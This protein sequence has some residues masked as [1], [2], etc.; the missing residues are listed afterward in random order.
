MIKLKLLTSFVLC[1]LLSFSQ[2]KKGSKLKYAD[3]KELINAMY[4]AYAPNKWYKYF[5]FSQTWSST[6]TIL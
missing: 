4:K 5:T 6:E 2:I 3:G 1:A